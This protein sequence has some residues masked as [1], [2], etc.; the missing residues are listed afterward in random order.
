MLRRSLAI[1]LLAPAIA[2]AAANTQEYAFTVAAA[3]KAVIQYCHHDCAQLFHNPPIPCCDLF[4][5]AMRGD[6]PA[7]RRVFTERG[8]HS[9]DNESWSFTA[10]P[11]L[12][13]VGDTHFAA[14]LHALDPKSQVEVFEQIFYEG[15]LYPR[16][17][18]SGYFARKFPR[19]EALYRKLPQRNASNRAM[20]LTTSR[21]TTQIS[22][23]STFHPAAIRVLARGSSSCSR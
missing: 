23:N 3:R 10:W 11:L 1:I 2:A 14:F 6:I 18:K 7:L 13:V 17:I 16:A 5:Q 8:L 4:E 21:R 19:V 20:E 12:H 15:S 9:G 22:M